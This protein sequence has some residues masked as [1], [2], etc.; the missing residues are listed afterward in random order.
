MD[1]GL[2]GITT[3][4]AL[5]G[6]CGGEYV[7]AR[8]ALGPYGDKNDGFV[9]RRAFRVCSALKSLGAEAIVLACNTATNA[10]IERL[11]AAD[12]TTTYI[13]VEPAV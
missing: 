8:D 4:A 10:A 6:T 13:G 7:Y 12:P 5:M 1:S 11:R 9:L 2:G 3:L